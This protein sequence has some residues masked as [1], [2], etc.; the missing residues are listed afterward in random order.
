MRRVDQ[1]IPFPWQS[2]DSHFAAMFVGGDD[3]SE[4]DRVNEQLAEREADRVDDLVDPVTI[5]LAG[6]KP[7]GVRAVKDARV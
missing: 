2:K 6:G 4:A 7:G 3:P 1:H 5:S